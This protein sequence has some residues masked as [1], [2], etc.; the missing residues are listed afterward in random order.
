MGRITGRRVKLCFSMLGMLPLA[1]RRGPSLGSYP[2]CRHSYCKAF[3]PRG[4]QVASFCSHLSLQE[5]WPNPKTVDRN[6]GQS[7]PSRPHLR[8]HTIFLTPYLLSVLAYA[9][10]H[11]P[12]VSPLAG[13]FSPQGRGTGQPVRVSTGLAAV[14]WVCARMNR[15]WANKHTLH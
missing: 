3:P 10:M 4:R 1:L 2:S 7:R 8:L 5:A 12:S 13:F 11:T 6:S 14:L 15:E 9:R